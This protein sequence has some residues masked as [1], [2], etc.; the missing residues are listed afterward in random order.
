MYFWKMIDQQCMN[1]NAGNWVR[2]ILLTQFAPN[3]KRSKQISYD[4]NRK[5]TPK[6][7]Y[8]KMHKQGQYHLGGTRAW[9]AVGGWSAPPLQSKDLPKF[10]PS[11]LGDP[12]TVALFEVLVTCC[13]VLCH[14]ATVGIVGAH[15][16]QHSFIYPALSTLCAEATG[17]SYHLHG[18]KLLDRA[19]KAPNTRPLPDQSSCY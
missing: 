8:T 19:Q 18:S 1:K 7:D 16:T 5:N 2:K 6:Q 10:D 12:A 3:N 13:S 14:S 17:V 4:L 9:V 15:L 11:G